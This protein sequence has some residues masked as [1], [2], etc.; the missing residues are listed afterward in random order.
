MK[1]KI[2]SVIIM[3]VV[4]MSVI[5]YK[6]NTVKA[7]S[8]E[9]T[10][11][12]EL[13]SGAEWTYDSITKKEGT[14]KE[15]KEILKYEKEEDLGTI[16]FYS[17]DTY[18]VTEQG[19]LIKTIFAGIGSSE[20][21]ISGN[22]VI[23]PYSEKNITFTYDETTKKLSQ[24]IEITVEN[25]TYSYTA[26]LT[27]KAVI[28]ADEVLKQIVGEWKVDSITKTNKDSE[29]F[30]EIVQYT[31]IDELGAYVFNNDNTYTVKDGALT[32]LLDNDNAGDKKYTVVENKITLS[33]SSLPLFYDEATKGLVVKYYRN[34]TDGYIITLKKVETNKTEDNKK[35]ENK[36]DENKNDEQEEKQEPQKEDETIAKEELPKAGKFSFVVFASAIF[37]LVIISIVSYKNR[38]I[39]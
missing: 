31:S 39:K 16:L 13:V 37:I 27:S 9:E 35:E 36:Q 2:F 32:S 1:K 21:T 24:D 12:K 25:T 38:L 5:S 22:Q 28:K 18:E 10:N 8:T 20:Y 29:D 14:T 33:S 30:N 3:V 19:Q 34:K 11:I 26:T 17:D 23:I 15:L 6:W 7:A 4:I